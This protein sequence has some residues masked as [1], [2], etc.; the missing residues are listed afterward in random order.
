M[1]EVSMGSER[2]VAYSVWPFYGQFSQQPL[3]GC[4]EQGDR[5]SS[6]VIVAP[7]ECLVREEDAMDGS[8]AEAEKG[9]QDEEY[10]ATVERSKSDVA[11]PPLLVGRR[12][13][14][15]PNVR[16]FASDVYPSVM[17]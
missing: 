5:G 6:V 1:F 7:A 9:E 4:F 14:G 3:P 10:S 15:L 11:S 17:R 12:R 8:C 2:F 16:G 13:A